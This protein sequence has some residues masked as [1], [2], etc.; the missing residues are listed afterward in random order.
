MKLYYYNNEKE[1]DN[2]DLIHKVLSDY[3]IDSG[4]FHLKKTEYSVLDNSLSEDKRIN[5]MDNYN[6]L[7]TQFSSLNEF[8]RDLV[9]LTRNFEYTDFILEKFSPIHF[10]FENEY[11]YLLDGN[12]EFG[13]LLNDGNKILVT[14]E[15][16]EFI[17]VPECT[18][19]WF[20]LTEEK[21]MAAIRY[22]FKTEKS[23]N[24]VEI[25]IGSDDGKL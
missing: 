19:Q 23:P 5:L 25:D 20:D 8:R 15:K 9:I 7:E 12:C 17:Q 24:K 13:F 10:H 16:G 2:L 11:W 14:L 21:N 22:F 1:T 6:D 4:S 3:G 18:W